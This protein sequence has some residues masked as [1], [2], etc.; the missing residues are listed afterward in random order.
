[1]ATIQP[2]LST[3]QTHVATSSRISFVHRFFYWCKM[4]EKNRL[5]WLAAILTIQGCVLTPLTL[6]VVAFTS[7][8]FIA[9]PFI[10]GAIGICLVTN[11]AAMPTKV[12]IPVFFFSVLIDVIVVG[13][14]IASAVTAG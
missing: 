5:G 10:I 9:W 2:S 11:L 7:T 13:N 1:M 4:Q 14:S 8:S 12:T 6:C 3:T